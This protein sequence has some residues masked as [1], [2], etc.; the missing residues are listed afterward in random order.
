MGLRKSRVYPPVASDSCDIVS[1]DLTDLIE[2]K[3]I[4]YENGEVSEF[5]WLR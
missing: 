4:A 3:L 2:K 1:V 5:G